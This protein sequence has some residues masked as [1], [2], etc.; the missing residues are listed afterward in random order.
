M[1]H[2]TAAAG[3]PP[4]MFQEMKQVSQPVERYAD[5]FRE[6][7]RQGL[8][9]FYPFQ[10]RSDW[11]P[12]IDTHTPMSEIGR[13]WREGQWHPDDMLLAPLR[14]SGGRLLG[15][16]S[17]DEPRDGRRPSQADLEVLAIFASQAAVAV[18]NARL[19]A[20][21]AHR[22][23]EAET[24]QAATQALSAT[25]DLQEI[26][27]VILRELQEVVPYD[28]AS[29]QQ[30]ERNQLR[31]VGGRGF[32]NL[33]EILGICLELA[34]EDNPNREVV[35]TR[36]PLI[37]DDAPPVYGAFRHGPLAPAGTRSWMGVPLLFGD[38]LIGMITLDK[39]EAGFYYW[40][41]RSFGSGICCTGGG[42]DAKCP[43]L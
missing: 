21:E 11:E 1:L 26:L 4:G 12:G 27:D 5:I 28:S 33:E 15:Y 32:P 40:G 24:L 2:R 37:V 7:Y 10:E 18:E 29:V 6:E 17:V 13:E 22:R 23:R 16:I 9:F 42:C 8:C 38:D 14:G 31:I 43:P 41:T 34:A 39:R 36:A 35:R 25:L 30:L 20:A 19:F 3:V